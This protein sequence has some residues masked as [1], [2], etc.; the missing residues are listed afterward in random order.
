MSK[1]PSLIFTVRK[2]V[3]F[4]NLI[5]F[6]SQT[7]I[8]QLNILSTSQMFNKKKSFSNYL[9]SKKWCFLYSVIALIMKDKLEKKVF[10]SQPDKHIQ[11]WAGWNT[12]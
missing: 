1:L 2:K 7:S 8:V 11:D 4:W 9:I 10:W 5:Y 6:S 3:V 12:Y